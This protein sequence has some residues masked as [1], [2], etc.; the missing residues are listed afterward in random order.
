MVLIGNTDRAFGPHRPTYPTP[1]DSLLDPLRKTAAMRKPQSGR[2]RIV[3]ASL[4]GQSD[5]SDLEDRWLRLAASYEFSD[6][7]ACRLNDQ[8]RHK[9][10]VRMILWSYSMRRRCYCPHGTCL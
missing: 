4:T 6:R 5:F 3:V 2:Q 1:V 8:S 10:N 9:R 7:L